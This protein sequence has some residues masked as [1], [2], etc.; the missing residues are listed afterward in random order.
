MI[1]I[2][3]I[4]NEQLKEIVNASGW[5]TVSYRLEKGDIETVVKKLNELQIIP[6]INE[7]LDRL[8]NTESSYK[9]FIKLK[10]RI[11]YYEQEKK[12]F[13]RFYEI[14]DNK[15]KND[16]YKYDTTEDCLKIIRS[17]YI[18][19]VDDNHFGLSLTHYEAGNWSEMIDMIND[20]LGWEIDREEGKFTEEQKYKWEQIQKDLPNVLKDLINNKEK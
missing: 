16:K 1:K 15:I 10:E 18:E 2:K 7:I 14:Q 5:A 4:T 11:D 8:N 6:A 19:I 3:E 17:A 13:S 12:K 20:N 9:S